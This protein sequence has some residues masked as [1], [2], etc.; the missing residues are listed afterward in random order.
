MLFREFQTLPGTD[1]ADTRASAGSPLCVRFP[2]SLAAASF[3][4]RPA[5]AGRRVIHAAVR[6]R[7]VDGVRA[8]SLRDRAAA[9]ARM[10]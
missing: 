4:R 8:L 1:F 3:S 5:A 7:M 6:A 2:G 9:D 10:G